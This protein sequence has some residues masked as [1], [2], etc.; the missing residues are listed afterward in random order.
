MGKV[1][2][3]TAIT[4]SIH[5]PSMTPYLPITP[6]QIADEAVKAHE[7]GAAMAHI[8]VRVPETG[9]PITDL[10]L[11]REVVTK[12]KKRCNIVLCL[13][14]GGGL[15]M[16]IEERLLQVPELKPELAS[17]NMGPIL[18]GLFPL[19]EKYKPFKYDWEITYLENTYDYVFPNTFKSLE[20][21]IRIMNE[22]GTKPECEVYEMGHI[23]LIRWLIDRGGMKGKPY[24]QFVL[25]M[26]G[27]MD[28]SV[29]N[30]VLLYEDA[31]SKIG[32]FN[33]SVG[34]A[35]K[36]QMPMVTTSMIMGGNVRVGLEDAMYIERGKLATSNAEQASK[37]VRIAHELGLEVASSDEARE[38][39]GLKGIDKVNF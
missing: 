31:R 23:N 15:G 5:T 25:G 11:F 38:I 24:I 34:A 32:D 4:G 19:I 18:I 9:K 13:T 1:I 3:T 36:D 28:A 17:F 27:P 26:M 35:G 14:T 7:A 2:I 30:L 29:K 33:W 10:N 12:V 16:T 20:T 22:N 21:Y 8:H 39:L 37:V 6:D